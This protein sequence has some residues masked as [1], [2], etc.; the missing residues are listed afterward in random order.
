MERVASALWPYHNFMAGF[1][2]MRPLA[3]SA[4]HL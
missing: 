3:L 1:E 4:M 2:K